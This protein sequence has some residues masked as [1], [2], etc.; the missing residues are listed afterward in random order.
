MPQQIKSFQR[1]EMWHADDFKLQDWDAS[2]MA[3]DP[4]PHSACAGSPQAAA[5]AA[6]GHADA[7]LPVPRSTRLFDAAMLNL[8]L[9]LVLAAAVL[10]YRSL[11][12]VPLL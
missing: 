8:V 1:L 5:A 10:V 6:G 2:R 11:L 9:M 3:P 12:P 4:G 7:P